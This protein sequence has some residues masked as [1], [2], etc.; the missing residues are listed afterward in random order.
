MPKNI[1]KFVFI[2]LFIVMSAIYAQPL[3]NEGFDGTTFPPLGWVTYDNVLDYWIND[4][5]GP[6]VAPGCAFA[7]KSAHAERCVVSN[8]AISTHDK[9]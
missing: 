6:H 5:N 8:T 1:Y 9:S 2:A 3:F 4:R 7:G